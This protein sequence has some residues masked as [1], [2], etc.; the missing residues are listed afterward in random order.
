MTDQLTNAL[1]ISCFVG[2]G[3]LLWALS[4][5]LV[6]RDVN[7]RSLPGFEQAAWL[8]L[9]ALL[10][11]IG[12]ITYLFA[13]LL[14]RFFSP[15]AAK[16]PEP[17]K[18]ITALK[19]PDQPGKRLPTIAAVDTFRPTI[20]S[21][22]LD[23]PAGST[24]DERVSLYLEVLKGP[25]VG[26]KYPLEILPV[27]IGRGPLAN[28]NLENDQGI[29]RQHAEIYEDMGRLRIRDLESTHGTFINGKRIVDE[30]LNPGDRITIG[31]S[32]LV[33]FVEDFD[34]TA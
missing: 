14:D 20:A 13:R 19:K 3:L 31:V 28:L 29:S 34:G 22:N 32:T 8:A 7:R 2:I 26:L 30:S 11:L 4:I 17:K 27:Y 9:A 18:R 5:A 23:V 21:L 6:L 1:I 12:G 16:K 24:K 33:L 10:P 25:I 15:G